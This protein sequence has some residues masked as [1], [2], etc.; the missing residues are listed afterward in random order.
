MIDTSGMTDARTLA[1]LDAEI[2][3]ATDQRSQ[4]LQMEEYGLACE[5]GQ[6][7]LD[8]LHAARKHVAAIIA[9]RDSFRE[10]AIALRE[11][12]FRCCEA[13]G[14]SCAAG[15]E[16]TVDDVFRC[17]L[18]EE[19]KLIADRDSLRQQA[20]RSASEVARLAARCEALEKA[21]KEALHRFDDL[22][23]MVSSKVWNGNYNAMRGLMDALP[24]T[25]ASTPT[26]KETQA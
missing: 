18:H 19:S 21:A 24:S 8:P 25:L 26:N 16:W 2:G 20:E 22:N 1:I 15:A 7:T 14:L 17:V 5:I 13:L 11:W 12:R 9:E 10:E 3:A 6:H 23:G 4:A